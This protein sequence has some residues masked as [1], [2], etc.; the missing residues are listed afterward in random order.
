MTDLIFILIITYLDDVDNATY[1]SG[2]KDS[3]I[4]QAHHHIVLFC[5]VVTFG[6]L[7]YKVICRFI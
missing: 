1:L 2:V 6:F 3:E 4:R 5:T 7:I